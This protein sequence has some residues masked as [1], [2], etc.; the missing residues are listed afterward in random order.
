V[1]NHFARGPLA[2]HNLFFAIRPPADKVGE[3]VD[4]TAALRRKIG[5]RP[6]RP[7]RLHITLLPLVVGREGPR[8]IREA[9]A[10]ADSVRRPPLY[11]IFD[12]AVGALNSALL[13]PSEPIGA[14][15]MF[16]EDLRAALMHFGVPIHRNERF[17]PHVTLLY[18]GQLMPEIPVDYVSWIA[19]E[20][21]LIDSLVGQ[22]RHVELGRWRLVA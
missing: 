5:G 7:D 22:T 2:Q 21:V 19:E 12:S 1:S 10:A 18:G 14:L 17:S 9:R 13:K 11:V 3:I 6:L 15:R 16:R 20:F 8:R 4:L